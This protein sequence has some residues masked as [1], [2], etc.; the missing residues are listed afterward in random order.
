MIPVYSA[1][2]YA[3]IVNPEH[4][5]IYCAIRDFY[6]AYIIYTFMQLLIQYLGG[7][8]Q[9]IIDL[10]FK[11]SLVYHLPYLLFAFRD[12]SASRGP[13]TRSSLCKPTGASCAS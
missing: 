4:M 6:E 13:S 10:E 8:K 2:T 1:T 5:L 7:Q 12:G 11:V 9:L 3:S